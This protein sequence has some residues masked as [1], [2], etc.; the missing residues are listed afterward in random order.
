MARGVKLANYVAQFLARLGIKH[1]FA[2]SGGASLRLIHGVAETPGIT[3]ICP[4]HEQAGAMA[5]DGYSR[6]TG[7]LGA[8]ITTSGPGATNLLTG[9]CCAYYDSVPVIFITGQ[10]AT[11]RMRG[12]T[13]VRQI[14]FQETATVDIYKPVTKYAV[15]ITDPK[16]IR[17]ELEKACAIATSGRP[18]PVLIDIPDNIQREEI[19]PELLEPF[20]SGLPPKK[21]PTLTK[22]I[23]KCCDF[24]AAAKRPM[25]ILGWGI[26]LAKAEKE[27]REFINNVGFPVVPTWGMADFLPASH[28]L[29]VGTFGTHG[30]RFANFAVQNAD[31]IFSIGSRLDTKA[32]GSP[33][34]TFAREAKKVVI[35]IDANELRKFEKFGLKIDL[36]INTDAK[37][38]LQAMNKRVAGIKKQNIAQWLKQIAHW[39]KKYPICLPRYYQEKDVN[40]Y[41]FVKELHQHCRQGEKLVVDTGCTIAWMMQGFAFKKGQRLYHDWNNTAMGWALPA[42]IGVSLAF[43][44]RPIIC[45][46]GDGALQMNIQ[47]L[48]TVMKHRLPLKIFLINNHGHSMIQQ[49]QD[50]W[51][52]SR[53]FASSVAGGLAFPDFSKVAMAYGFRTITITKNNEVGEKIRTVLETAGPVFC[54]VEIKP[55]QHVIPQVRFG[56]PNEDPE[57]LLPRKEFLQNMLV[58]L[59]DVS[60]DDQYT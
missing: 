24:I 48:V 33:A 10:V 36:L 32:T 31:L 3:F 45:I 51:Y 55:E 17:Y 58:P 54:N 39:K 26:R 11:F 19:T 46:T 14:G 2:V 53:Y 18:G 57:P 6:A 23:K 50:Q 8:A 59:L 56:R 13:G 1:V 15:L 4:Q 5:A 30:T 37:D 21:S 7:K 34:N 12:S 41:V 29:T 60:L 9:V 25:I 49:T 28:P 43:N 42:S 22:E 38:F 27:T 52:G 44:K 47:E 40:P 35:D 16:K 20:R